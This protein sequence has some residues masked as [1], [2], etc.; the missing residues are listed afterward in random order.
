MQNKRIWLIGASEGIGAALAEQL[1]AQGAT[2]LLS[3]RNAERLEMLRSHLPGHGHTVHPLDVTD[4]QQMQQVWQSFG[5][6]WPDI[7]IYNAGAY[8]P[9]EAQQLDIAAVETMLDVNLRGAFRCA[10]TVLPTWLAQ[11]RGHLVLV[12]SVAGYR[13]LPKAMGYGASKA[14]VNHLAENLRADLKGTGIKVQLVCPGF[15]KT[16]LTDQNSFAMPFIITP[17]QAAAHIVRG[18]GTGRG[19]GRAPLNEAKI[20]GSGQQTQQLHDVGETFG[21]VDLE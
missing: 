21:K 16:R 7:V 3:A 5:E 14:G 15:V 2:L 10:A 9:M 11:G 18:M 13:G 1:A 12:G 17:Q 6:A 19:A 8:T 4:M 20:Q